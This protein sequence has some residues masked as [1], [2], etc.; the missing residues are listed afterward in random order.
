MYFDPKL[1]TFTKG[2]RGRIA[3]TVV[4]GVLAA[5]VGIARLAL[6]GWLLAQVFQGVPLTDLV[7]PFAGIALV[8]L[9]RGQLEYW[10]TMAAHKTAAIVQLHI[11]KALFDRIV[12]LGPAYMGLERTGAVITSMVDGVEQ[13]ETYF[14]RYRSFS[15]RR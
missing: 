2:V 13:L 8:M 11:R 15:W 3:G 10:R 4:V 5:A 7:Y 14:G 12:D 9:L 1:W 6:L